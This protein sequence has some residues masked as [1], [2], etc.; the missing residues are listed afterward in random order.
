MTAHEAPWPW[1]Y[2]PALVGT[3]SILLDADGKI[4]AVD[5]EP[6]IMALYEARAKQQNP[7]P[8]T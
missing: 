7:G 1:R 4:I 3:R 8:S 2:E 5:E 6:V